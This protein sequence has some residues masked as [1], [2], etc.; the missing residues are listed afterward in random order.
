MIGVVGAGTIGVGVAQDLAQHGFEVVLLDASRDALNLA[1]QRLIAGLRFAALFD[2]DLRDADHGAILDRVKSTTTYG[3]LAEATVIVENTT[4][5]WETKVSVYNLLS[6]ICPN[7]CLI[8]ANTSAIA[9]SRLASLVSNPQ[10][11]L[12]MHFMNPVPQ[13]KFV[14]VVKSKYTS[15][16][17]MD[18]ASALLRS[19]GKRS[20][21]VNDMPGFVSNRIL[22]LTINEAASVLQ[23]GVASAREVDQIFVQCFGHKMGPLAT[24]DLIG[25]DTIVNTLDVLRGSFQDDKYRPCTLLRSMVDAG[26]H[27]RKTGMGFFSGY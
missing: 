1:E 7:D 13:K 17:T 19:L 14:E 4:E 27:G 2:K 26:K 22:M 3:D 18:K 21:V 12:G 5:L 23:D 11:V 10:R 8:A 16:A 9:I 25:I 20:I 15:Q 24:A 6:Q